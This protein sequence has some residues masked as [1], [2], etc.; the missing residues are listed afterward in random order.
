MITCVM[1]VIVMIMREL[2]KYFSELQRISM[3]V[4]II[5]CNL[6]VYEMMTNFNGTAEGSEKAAKRYIAE[7]KPRLK[8]LKSQLKPPYPE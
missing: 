4:D 6:S 2:N 7:I 1:C 5:E 3:N 8:E